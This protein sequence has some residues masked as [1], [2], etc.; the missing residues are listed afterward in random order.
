M[1]KKSNKNFPSIS[2][3]YDSLFLYA[4]SCQWLFLKNIQKRLKTTSYVHLIK[5]LYHTETFQTKLPYCSVIPLVPHSHKSG[6]NDY[7][8]FGAW[9]TPSVSTPRISKHLVHRSSLLPSFFL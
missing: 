9:N 5:I 1:R 7:G 6:V 3:V 4:I 2:Y 8:F